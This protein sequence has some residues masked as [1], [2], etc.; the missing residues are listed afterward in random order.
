MTLE[1]F[2]FR[3]RT[4]NGVLLDH[5]Q[6]QAVDEGEAR[7]KLIRMYPRCEILDSHH[8]SAG[9]GNASKSF[10]DIADLLNH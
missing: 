5:L 8:E 6:I 9:N 2:S 1:K 7:A 10:E 4:H 3:I